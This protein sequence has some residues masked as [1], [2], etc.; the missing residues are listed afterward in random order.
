MMSE[1]SDYF[2]TCAAYW[3]IVAEDAEGFA[4]EQAIQQRTYYLRKL[5]MLALNEE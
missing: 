5:G 3:E 1:Q 4:L 2:H